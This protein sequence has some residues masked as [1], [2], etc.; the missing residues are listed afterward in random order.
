MYYKLMDELEYDMGDFPMSSKRIVFAL[1]AEDKKEAVK[2]F[3]K[4][5]DGKYLSFNYVNETELENSIVE[6]TI[7]E[8]ESVK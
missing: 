1:E 5:I 8:Y 2:Q 7:K 3:K 6:C 4:L